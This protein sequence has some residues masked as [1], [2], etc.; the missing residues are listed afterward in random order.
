MN[1]GDADLTWFLEAPPEGRD[2]I[3]RLSP[4]VVLAALIPRPGGDIR[5]DGAGVSVGGGACR[6]GAG[7]ADA[8]TAARVPRAKGVERPPLRNQGNS[9]AANEATSL[10]GVEV[11]RRGLLPAPDGPTTEGGPG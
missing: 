6:P 9:E 11:G 1:A 3:Q 5:S 7:G 2:F 8:G 10:P 4:E